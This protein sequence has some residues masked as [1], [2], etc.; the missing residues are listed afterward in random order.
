MGNE[1]QRVDVLAV[2]DRARDVLAETY[3]KYQ[4]KI[5]PFA[6]QSQQ[7]NAELRQAR[8]AVA[9]FIREVDIVMQGLNAPCTTTWQAA[10]DRLRA[11]L[12]RVGGAK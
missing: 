8:D 4:T 5:G 11:A 6:S 10:S 9:R 12:A 3:A 2:M 1:T 7:S